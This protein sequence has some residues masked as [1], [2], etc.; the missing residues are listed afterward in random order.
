MYKGATS[1][2]CYLLKSF[3][4][5]DVVYVHN[6]TNHVGVGPIGEYACYIGT[7]SCFCFY[8][9]FRLFFVVLILGIVESHISIVV[10]VRST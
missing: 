4:C 7:F 10:V 3:D 2:I 1:I 5:C 6:Y 8:F 9:H